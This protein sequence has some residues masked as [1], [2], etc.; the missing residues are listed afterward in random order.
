MRS[1]SPLHSAPDFRRA[2]GVVGEARH[3]PPQGSIPRRRRSARGPLCIGLLLLG[4]A[5]A[6]GCRCDPSGPRDRP[7]PRRH[8]A[9]RAPDANHRAPRTSS[10]PR[11]PPLPDLLDRI[12][13]P[14]RWAVA[15]RAPL[16][17]L[18][19]V[20]AWMR[21]LKPIPGA[22]DRA[23]AAAASLAAWL[24]AWPPSSRT[25]ELAGISPWGGVA[26]ARLARPGPSP[27]YALVILSRHPARAL[28]TLRDFGPSNPSRTPPSAPGGAGRPPD[29][30][31]T[32]LPL[33]GRVVCSTQADAVR[34]SSS[35][36][37]LP[38]S[39]SMTR[40]HPS[41]WRQRL[42]PMPDADGLLYWR[43][44][45]ARGKPRPA[46]GSAG[47][48]LT[49]ADARSFRLYLWFRPGTSRRK[50]PSMARALRDNLA[51]PPKTTPAPPWVHAH[52]QTPGVALQAH[53]Q[54][55]LP[56]WIC[57]AGQ[58]P[59][60]PSGGQDPADAGVPPQPSRSRWLWAW[61][62][63]GGWTVQV[64]ASP[65]PLG[66]KPQRL[67]LG[68]LHLPPLWRCRTGLPDLCTLASTPSRC[69][70]HNP[71][72]PAPPPAPPTLAPRAGPAPSI[73]WPPIGRNASAWLHV[74]SLSMKK[75]LTR[76]QQAHLMAEL[77]ALHEGPRDVLN[78]LRVLL[79][80]AGPL[81]AA[82][83]RS[84]QA[85]LEVWARL[86]E[87]SSSKSRARRMAIPEPWRRWGGRLLVRAVSRLRPAEVECA[88]LDARLLACA[89][90]FGQ[91][92]EPARW[93]LLATLSAPD[94]RERLLGRALRSIRVMGH[95]CEQ[96]RGRMDNAKELTACLRIRG[97]EAFVRC[98]LE[99]FRWKERS[100]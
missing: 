25:L 9:L 48:L 31:H 24:G 70:P 15:V 61:L 77:L 93:H 12:G 34:C 44:P 52:G 74:E 28:A 4:G 39:P 56:S 2:V 100:G 40:G 3:H 7:L 51:P 36:Q 22:G 64:G 26:L 62:S 89:T 19:R 21:R 92:T 27:A 91:A 11:S 49:R 5:L 20:A 32:A 6:Q 41:M 83:A 87:S 79:E 72:R 47:L 71:R 98:V 57:R 53:L 42:H 81:D 86:R 58:R 55:S 45:R 63:P 78:A 46:S 33:L 16:R 10:P 23:R 68:A 96:R 29:A 97:C 59:P 14:V 17:W 84:G 60:L 66:R 8:S 54:G 30:I 1:P 95:R 43:P 37:A 38:P 67:L 35:R 69:S 75:W 76:S 50:I 88:G 73:R 99:A 13:E 94:A 85:G 65:S 18:R 80:A 82:A 90:A